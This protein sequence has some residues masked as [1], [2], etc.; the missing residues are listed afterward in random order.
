MA[1]LFGPQAA[2]HMQGSQGLSVD[3]ISAPLCQAWEWGGP[4]LLRL[5][6]FAP[7]GH[8]PVAP[9]W[10]WTFCSHWAWCFSHGGHQCVHLHP[11]SPATSL[12]FL[13]GF[14][15]SN[16]VLNSLHTLEFNK[17]LFRYVDLHN[18][19]VWQPF[20]EAS[21]PKTH[22]REAC[23]KVGERRWDAGTSDAV[24]SHSLDFQS[25]GSKK[26]IAVMTN[27][28][29]LFSLPIIWVLKS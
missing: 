17:L 23:M 1:L 19:P 22:R 4:F 29:G 10:P 11:K 9:T 2:T 5:G 3:S 25:H 13:S 8:F 15:F 7:G 20:H 12:Y 6:E 18:L 14:P 21:G 26:C 24:F 27:C 16:V 28:S